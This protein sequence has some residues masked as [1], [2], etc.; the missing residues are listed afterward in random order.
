M[1]KLSE[2]KIYRLTGTVTISVYTV[3]E[4]DSLEDALTEAADRP[5]ESSGWNSEEQKKE[6]WLSDEFD[7]EVDNMEHEPE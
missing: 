4:A 5:I 6:A 3:V 7:G 1:S 2:M